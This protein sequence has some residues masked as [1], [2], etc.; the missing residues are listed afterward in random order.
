MAKMTE[1]EQKAHDFHQ[2]QLGERGH[3][4][5]SASNTAG[6]RNYQAKQARNER[7]ANFDKDFE[8][9]VKQNTG[10]CFP[11]GTKVISTFGSKDISEITKGESVLSIDK[12]GAPR[13]CR[14][15]EVVSH[16]NNKIWNLAFTD[17]S[18]LRTTAVH[19]FEVNGSRRTARRI[20]PGDSLTHVGEHNT[21][22]RKTVATSVE[23]ND[24][25]MVYNLIVDQDFNFVADGVLAFSFTYFPLLRATFWRVTQ[26]I[27]DLI[28]RQ[29]NEPIGL[30]AAN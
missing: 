14:V 4:T 1:Q 20:E 13:F 15:L 22:A 3:S 23:S 25:E 5:G 28:S 29:I 30:P 17:G 8:R 7:N 27:S 9:N 21:I 16:A 6:L 24:L 2:K 19:S 11:A 18:I 10:G 12:G 26:K